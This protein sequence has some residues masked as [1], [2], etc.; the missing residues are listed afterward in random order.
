M[1]FY[2]RFKV[3]LIGI[4]VTGEKQH[5]DHQGDVVSQHSS[6]YDDLAFEMYVD[7]GIAEIIR[8]LENRKISAVQGSYFYSL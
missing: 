2:C 8:M 5:T 7:K 4:Q 6:V 3:S 1:W